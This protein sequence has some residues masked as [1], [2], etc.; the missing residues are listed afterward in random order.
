MNGSSPFGARVT[1][2]WVALYTRSLPE[3]V[4]ERRRVEIESDLWEQLND[5]SAGRTSARV[6]DRCLR[7]IPADVWWRYRTLLEQREVRQRN[8]NMT[9]NI[10][11]NWW[12]AITAVLGVTMVTLGGAGIIFGDGDGG[13]AVLAAVT[14]ISGGLILGGLALVQQRVVV[15]SWMIVGG[16]G[17]T[18]LSIF[19]IPIAAL[20][21]IGGLWTGPPPA[22][23][24]TIRRRH[25]QVVPV[26]GRS[27]RAVH[28]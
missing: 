5:G 2:S 6:L 27:T 20:I 24:S 10:L 13:G 25:H 17:V 9:R 4:G 26:A 15:G 21:V 18:I 28:D 12:G 22:G 19:M 11:T 7:G 3:A 16:A 14:L 1:R 8:Q 23:P